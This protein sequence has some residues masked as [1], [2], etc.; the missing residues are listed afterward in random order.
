MKPLVVI[1]SFMRNGGHLDAL[2]DTLESI[3][4]TE[5]DD[6]PDI[7][8]V[9]DHSPDQSLVEQLDILR[10]KAAEP[11]RTGLPLFEMFCKKENSGFSRTVNFGLRRAREEG[12]DAVLMNA[13]IE[14]DVPGWVARCQDTQDAEGRPAAMVGA[15]LIYPQSGLIQ[16]A[17]I[18]FSY[19]TRRFFER[20]KYAP[21]N[22]PEALTLQVLPVTGAFQYI[23]AD[24]LT[25]VGVYDERFRLGYEDVDYSIRVFQAGLQCVFN[26][27]IR[28]WHHESM[29]RGE[30]TEQVV[31]WEA[32]SWHEFVQKYAGESFAAY[33]PSVL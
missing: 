6:T 30:K 29:I 5:P 22:L 31:R 26:P 20:F 16:H 17:G 19:L 11:E 27:N 12:R 28:A 32:T 23:R 13:D 7:L 24:T 9:D 1:P 15:L 21:A 2:V 8:V 14:M 3:R 4:R 18:N 10:R 25:R 33:V